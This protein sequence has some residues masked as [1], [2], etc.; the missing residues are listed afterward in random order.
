MQAYSEEPLSR[1]DAA[2]A[3][4]DAMKATKVK[5]NLLSPVQEYKQRHSYSF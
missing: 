2:E 3:C 1:T 4:C 5:I